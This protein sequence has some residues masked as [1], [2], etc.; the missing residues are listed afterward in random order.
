MLQPRL[1]KV[2]AV[3]LALVLPCGFAGHLAFA[4]SNPPQKKD[5]PKKDQQREPAPADKPDMA[6]PSVVPPGGNKEANKAGPPGQKTAPLPKTPAEREKAL[7]DLYALLA[8]SDS[9]DS[10]KA[11]AEGIERIWLHSGSATVDLLMERAMKAVAQ[12]KL[13]LGIKL[14]DR[15]VEMAP[16]YPE[17]WN[18]RAYA[19]YKHEDVERA[20]G[21]LRRTLALDPNHFKALDGLSQILREV[22]QKKGALK[23]LRQLL[24]VHPYWPNAQ[25]TLDELVREVEGQ[26][27]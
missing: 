19:H 21:D 16:D 12:N 23:A 27:I 10:A 9:E 20:L 25:Q 6:P 8:T 15:V 4:Q 5:T 17:A 2:S 1:L 18:R 26:G 7:N 14:L 13:E 22:G 3:L 11:V 24:D